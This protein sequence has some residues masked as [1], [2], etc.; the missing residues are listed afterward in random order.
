M[1]SQADIGAL[2]AKAHLVRRAVINKHCETAGCFLNSASPLPHRAVLI[3]PRTYFAAD[4]KWLGPAASAHRPGV[5]L[6]FAPFIG[7]P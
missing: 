6:L 4:R 1:P 3:T 2:A 7:P 5:H